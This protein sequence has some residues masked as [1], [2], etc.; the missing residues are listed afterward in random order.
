M[1]LT[2]AAC[3]D[4]PPKPA[5]DAGGGGDG[6]AGA[7]CGEPGGLEGAGT[8]QQMG[9]AG[10]LNIREAI[11]A[12][13]NGDDIDDLI[14]L[15]ADVPDEEN[16]VVLVL[17]GP[18]SED[19]PVIHEKITTLAAPGAVAVAEL[20]GDSCL[21]L[22]VFGANKQTDNGFIEL[23]VNNAGAD[24]AALFEST[25]ATHQTTFRPAYENAPA[26]IVPGRFGTDSSIDFVV[27]DL[28][29]VSLISMAGVP[30]E[31]L[32][33]AGDVELVGG[34]GATLINGV[35]AFPNG[36]D[37]TVDDLVIVEHSDIHWVTRDGG[38]QLTDVTSE[39]TGSGLL[40]KAALVA[41][42]DDAAPPGDS[43]DILGAGGS[44]IGAW[45][46]ADDTP[47]SISMVEV[48]FANPNLLADE[49]IGQA[50]L[51]LDDIVAGPLI[52]GAAID[53][54]VFDHD[55]VNG[56]AAA[57]IVDV[58][59]DGAEFPQTMV[60]STKSFTDFNPRAAAILDADADGDLDVYVIDPTTGESQCLEINTSLA[61]VPCS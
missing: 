6:G 43:P 55:P 53:V 60:D 4:I 23:Y 31:G 1:S 42:I 11:P 7:R 17:L 5:P 51:D 45:R 48:Q 50:D 32:V 56:S 59:R 21:D 47:G 12:D 25:P 34:L 8:L 29:E 18:L 39:N 36:N 27:A 15:N 22:A 24:P 44:S 37:D 35:F 19:D 26:F 38:N 13:V 30:S 28:D 41:Q 40:V 58:A 10:A 16:Q 49:G 52:Q 14:V 2:T 57:V 20:S 9:G 61:L 33:D 3:L 54:V 46:I